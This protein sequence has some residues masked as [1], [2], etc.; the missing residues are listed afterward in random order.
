[1]NPLKCAFG[2]T[3]RKFLGFVVRSHGIEIERRKIAA[4]M[5]EPHNIHELKS[6][7]GKVAYLRRFISNLVR[8]CQPFS[9]LM[10]KEIPYVWDA[11]L[12]AAFQDIKSYLMKPPVLAALVQGKPLILYVAAQEQ[13]VGPL[14]ALE[15]EEGNK[16]SLYYLSG[17]MTS[18]ELKYTPIEK[19]AL[20]F[21]IHKLKHYFQAHVVRLISKELDIV[22]V[23][24][25]VVKWQVLA[26]FLG[27][28][29]L[30]LEWELCDELPYEDV[31]NIELLPS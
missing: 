4:T 13:S 2:V 10:K 20:I 6:M 16:N 15:N 27:E 1:M 24:Q 25:K 9:K 7:E 30:A 28:H 31:I 22:Y 14:L 12:S 5:P 18:N 17:R 29:P 3:S 26:D 19:L 8:K 21:T 23:P 11:A